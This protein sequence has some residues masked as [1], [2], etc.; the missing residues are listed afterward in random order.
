MRVLVVHALKVNGAIVRYCDT[1]GGA[2]S[3][4]TL[5]MGLKSRQFEIERVECEASREGLARLLNEV[6]KLSA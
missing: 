3:V 6:C 5:R 2:R 1:I 4:A